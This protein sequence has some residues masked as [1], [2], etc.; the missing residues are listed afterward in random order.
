MMTQSMISVAINP[1]INFLSTSVLD[2]L[3]DKF[4]GD[5]SPSEIKHYECET[6]DPNVVLWR[7]LGAP[8]S[9]VAIYNVLSM[10]VC[11]GIICYGE[12]AKDVLFQIFESRGWTEDKE[13]VFMQE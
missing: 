9:V 8:F 11:Y 1:E 4:I 13:Y 7:V 10:Q 2:K 12:E 5:V 6:S 3:C